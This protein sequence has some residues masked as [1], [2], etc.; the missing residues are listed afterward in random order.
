MANVQQ[1][2]D[3]KDFLTKYNLKYAFGNQ[4]NTSTQCIV[5]QL[6]NGGFSNTDIQLNFMI[7][8]VGFVAFM[9]PLCKIN[10]N[11]LAVEVFN[12]NRLN[13]EATLYEKFYIDEDDCLC[14]KAVQDFVM[15]NQ[16]SNAFLD[17]YNKYFNKEFVEKFLDGEIHYDWKNKN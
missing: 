5:V 2:N 8:D 3:L 17:Y 15:N 12:C 16:M 14:M 11:K 4:P 1:I 6:G 7:T 9:G 10:E 13:Q